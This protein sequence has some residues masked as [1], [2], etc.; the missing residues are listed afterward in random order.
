MARGVGRGGGGVGGGRQELER[1]QRQLR[2]VSEICAVYEGEWRRGGGCRCASRR[3]GLRRG[4]AGGPVRQAVP[5]RLA[6]RGG[7][8]LPITAHTGREPRR[9][10]RGCGGAGGAG[11]WGPGRLSGASQS[12]SAATRRLGGL[13]PG[14]SGPRLLGRFMPRGSWVWLGT[15]PLAAAL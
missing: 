12:G 3:G 9:G 2:V 13:S 14:E 7:G 5:G 1:Y 11:A 10:C 4:G 6:G 15:G 8:A